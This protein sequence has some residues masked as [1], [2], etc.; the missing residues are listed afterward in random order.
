MH[1]VRE[2]PSVLTSEGIEDYFQVH[3][4]ELKNP[5]FKYDFSFYTFLNGV[6]VRHP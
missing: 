6:L 1:E 5:V 2:Y 4:K 3:V